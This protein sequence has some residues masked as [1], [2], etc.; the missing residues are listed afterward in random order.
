MY[1]EKI[2]LDEVVVTQRSYD[3]K[4]DLEALRYGIGA[5]MGLIWLIILFKQRETTIPI[6]KH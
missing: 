4:I 1:L 3:G 6:E 2:G 5:L